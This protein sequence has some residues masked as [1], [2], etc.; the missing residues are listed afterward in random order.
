MITI[1]YHYIR[2][3]QEKSETIKPFNLDTFVS[4]LDELSTNYYLPSLDEFVE[5]SKQKKP[6]PDNW[7]LLTFDDGLKDHF[8]NVYPILKKKM[9]GI[10]FISTKPLIENSFICTF[11]NHYFIEKFGS[12][13][14]FNIVNK[15][16][17]NNK[18]KFNQNNFDN[19]LKKFSSNKVIF[20][21]KLFNSR[22]VFECDTDKDHFIKS[23]H[24]NYYKELTI[25]D[26]H[27]NSI[28]INKMSND[29]MLIGSHSVTHNYMSDL[30]PTE[31]E[32][33]IKNSFE[34]LE[35]ITS[36]KTLRV[37]AF[38]YG[39]R[40]TYNYHSLDALSKNQVDIAFSYND[41]NEIMKNT[42]NWHYLINRENPEY[43]FN[44][45]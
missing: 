1:G 24:N 32:K 45:K 42:S 18:L 39:K 21:K 10:F 8:L 23:V 34:I 5:Y 15:V 41:D 33:E 36:N 26:I 7:F 44:L 6:F 19:L 9:W 12:E 20:L 37:F 16:I 4:Q 38:P 29:G 14:A 31:Q 40:F 35:N 22:L 11:F 28:E 27:L 25:D 17:N 30:S 43:F 2:N 3:Q 13:E